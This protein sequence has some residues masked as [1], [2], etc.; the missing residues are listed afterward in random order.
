[1]EGSLETLTEFGL[2]G[3]HRYPAVGIDTNPGIQKR[4]LLE[5]AGKARGGSRGWRALTLGEGV[6]KREAYDQRA[7]AREHVATV[8]NH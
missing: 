5:A 1:L 3:E 4:R 8:E 7:A 6:R 2:A